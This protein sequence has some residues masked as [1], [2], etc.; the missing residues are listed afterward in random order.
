MSSRQNYVACLAHFCL[1]AQDRETFF[2][3]PHMWAQSLLI[4]H[5]FLPESILSVFKFVG[6]E[7][8][9]LRLDFCESLLSIQ[10][11]LNFFSG[12]FVLFHPLIFDLTNGTHQEET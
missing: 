11:A 4:S 5:D 1:E 8:S 12:L 2:F 7:F 9:I 10:E 3:F 6:H